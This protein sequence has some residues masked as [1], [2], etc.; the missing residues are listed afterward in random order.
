MSDG[1][2]T[3]LY[4]FTGGSDG[5]FPYSALVQGS[6]GNFYGTTYSYGNYHDGTIFEITTNGNV[7]PLISFTGTSGSYLGANPQ[8][9]LV[10]GSDGN[11]YGTTYDGGAN[12]KGTVFR[13]SLP[14]PPVFKSV[15]NNAGTVTLVWSAVA[16]QSYQLQYTTNLAPAAWNNL[17]GALT[18]TNGL[19]MTNSIGTDPQR[20]YRVVLQ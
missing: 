20:F 3:N 17:G 1:T 12:N 7:T 6:D 15:A 16:G 13:L 2:F 8:G 19:M 18:A 10:Q 4:S 11:F 5:A 9:S 14:L